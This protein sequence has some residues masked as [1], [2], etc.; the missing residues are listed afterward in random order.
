MSEK[1]KY[2]HELKY[3]INYQEYFLIR[4]R[5]RSVLPSDSN[6]DGDGSYTVRSLYFDDYNNSSYYDKYAGILKRAKHR[7]R[8]YNYS[9]QRINYEKKNKYGQYNHK[10]TALITKEQ[11]Y[12]ILSGDFE[13]LLKSPNSLLSKLYYECRINLLRPR[14]IVDYEREPYVLAAGD[15]RL[16]FDKNIR[17]GIDGFD[18]FD[19]DIPTIETMDPGTL[20]MEVKYTEFLPNIVRDILA[21]SSAL[22]VESSKYILCCDKMLHT[23]GFNT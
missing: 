2:R 22:Y 4:S 1:K 7:I 15:V 3:L 8:I 17:A 12:A 23:R 14:I 10:E 18:I 13:F 19:K 16:T 20:V 21:S 6:V 5:V 11:F 9:D